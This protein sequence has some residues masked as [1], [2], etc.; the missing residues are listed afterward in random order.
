MTDTTEQ[1]PTEIDVERLDEH[2]LRDWTA[3]PN[4]GSRDVWTRADR[5]D[6]TLALECRSC[7]EAGTIQVGRPVPGSPEGGGS[8]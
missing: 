8:E 6:N 3:C 2:E 1:Q 5:T 4:C 7:G